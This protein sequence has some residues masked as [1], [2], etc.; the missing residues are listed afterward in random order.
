MNED[1]RTTCAALA[2]LLRAGSVLATWGFALSVVAGLM[3]ALR[4]LPM[5]S[6]VA[7]SA[8]AILGV[9]ERYFAFRLRLDQRLFAELSRGGID[10]LPALDGALQRLG[11][12]PAGRQARNLADRVRGTRALMRRQAIVVSS[13]S[14]M[15]LLALL[16]Q[17]LS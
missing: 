3:L 2:A 17:D 16:T 7:L 1:D 11:L 14:A 8:V 15:F 4:S 10:S 13:Q 6:A 5:M 9:P 12:R